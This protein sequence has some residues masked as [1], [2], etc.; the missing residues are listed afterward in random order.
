MLT[1]TLTVKELSALHKLRDKL[2]LL[3]ILTLLYNEGKYT[4]DT[5]A[6]SMH[7]EVCYCKNSSVTQRSRL[8]FRPVSH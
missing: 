3:L 6:Y 1:S 4:K 7:V 8:R 5:D 2:V